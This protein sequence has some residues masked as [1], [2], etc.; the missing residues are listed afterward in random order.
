MT[1]GQGCKNHEAERPKQMAQ[2]RAHNY[3]PMI[4][5]ADEVAPSLPDGTKSRAMASHKM[6]SLLS[7][8]QWRTSRP[9]TAQ[10]E[11]VNL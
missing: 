11:T 10:Y 3:A 4:V 9:F 2:N 1:G 5:A 8:P 7:S 6:Q